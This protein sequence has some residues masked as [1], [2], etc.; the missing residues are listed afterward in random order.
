M[1]KLR[2][3]AILVIVTAMLLGACNGGAGRRVDSGEIVVPE[4]SSEDLIVSS[5]EYLLQDDEES[6]EEA[7]E[8]SEEESQDVEETDEET[9]DHGEAGLE[10]VQPEQEFAPEGNEAVIYYGNAGSYDLKQEMIQLEEKTA[11]ELLGALAKHNIVS[12]DTKVLSFEEKETSGERILHLELSRAVSE[13][14][15]TMS[16]EAECIILASLVNTFLENYDADGVYIVV[17]GEPLHTKNAEY[18][19]ALSRC[20]PEE[21]LERITLIEE[22]DKEEEPQETEPAGAESE[23]LGEETYGTDQ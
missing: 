18:A 5:L 2:R 9:E 4:M 17:D 8:S 15:K 20:T 12:L 3:I 21:L 16:K 22:I 13:Y 14:L 11:D 10:S 6:A 1:R 7:V 23:E 19:E